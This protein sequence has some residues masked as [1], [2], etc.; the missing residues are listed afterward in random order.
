V[1]SNRAT[2]TWK[3]YPTSMTNPRDRH[4]ALAID[5][6]R[7][8]I[9]GGMHG[10]RALNTVELLKIQNPDS[11]DEYQCDYSSNF[12]PPEMSSA[13]W[14]HVSAL[15]KDHV[16]VIGG[17]NSRDF[18]P[19][20]SVKRL[21]VSNI[22]EPSFQPS[23][24]GAKSM[25]EA[26]QD[27]CSAS[28]DDFIY[29]FGGYNQQ[30][31]TY[32][33]ST[34]RYDTITNR[35]EKVAPMKQERASHAAVTIGDKI[36]VF[37]GRV[38]LTT[39]RST[40]IFDI[41]TQSWKNGPNM[42]IPLWGMAA[43]AI[44]NWIVVVGGRSN[45]LSQAIGESFTYDTETQIWDKAEQNLRIP[46][47][48]HSAAVV[49]DTKIVVLGGSSGKSSEGTLDTIEYISFQDLTS[50][51]LPLLPARSDEFSL[52]G[53]GNEHNYIST[54]TALS[55][56][57]GLTCPTF[58][59]DVFLS[60]NWGNDEKNRDNH[61]RVSLIHKKLSERGIR[62]WFDSE[63]MTGNI[64]DQMTRG[65]DDSM[66]VITFITKAYIVKVAG[67][68]A[69]EDEDN[70][71]LEFGYSRNRKGSSKM[72]PVV[73]EPS[74]CISS[75]WE[76]A[77]GATLGNHLYYSFVGDEQLDKCVDELIGKIKSIKEEN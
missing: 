70:C 69:K 27:F 11:S 38:G 63:R 14:G 64:L 66:A 45:D 31:E 53:T 9:T 33:S 54:S 23:W 61:H 41:R 22:D 56:V 37:G 43:V 50:S 15:Y 62:S 58:K 52:Q 68:G 42:R 77:V 47:Y 7:I 74:C 21:N 34:E 75:E 26:R 73:M 65:I 19:M 29:V 13:R 6:D 4:A 57:S 46:R 48:D 30:T 49:D 32:L 51:S 2:S 36:Y 20:K 18:I 39:L 28:H 55:S 40:E 59:Y 10:S 76:G 60:H 25:G 5:N 24:E 17:Y 16:Y 72:I 67:R 3:I 44:G 12:N 35:W 71:K 8:V 1:K